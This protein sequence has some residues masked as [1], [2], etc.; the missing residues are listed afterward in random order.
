MFRQTNRLYC[1]LQR[2]FLGIRRSSTDWNVGCRNIVTGTELAPILVPNACWVADPFLFKHKD[3]VFLFVELFNRETNKGS[4]A[5][6]E[7]VDAEFSMIQICLVEDFHLSFPRV[8]SFNGNVYLTVESSSKPGV[9]LYESVTFPHEWKYLY[10]I[11]ESKTYV[12]PIIFE[13]EDNLYLVVSG[14]LDPNSNEIYFFRTH[15]PESDS[16]EGSAGNPY[17]KPK[18]MARNAGFFRD[19]DRL[20]RVSQRKYAGV[21]GFDVNLHEIS[22]PIDFDRFI[23]VDLENYLFLKPLDARQFH[24][25]NKLGDFIVY[26]YKS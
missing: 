26:D 22:I 20:I 16:W 18:Q 24:T 19:G 1:R 3:Q 10:S 6:C 9:R 5:F 15:A 14:R 7:I 25:L 12:D 13:H 8:I 4:I 21:Y 23:E 17:R 2:I 11:D